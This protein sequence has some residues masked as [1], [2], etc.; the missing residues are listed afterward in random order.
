MVSRTGFEV[1]PHRDPSVPLNTESEYAHVTVT[2]VVGNMT[3]TYDIPK[4]NDLETGVVEY[5]PDRFRRRTDV[6]KKTGPHIKALTFSVHPFPTDDGG[7][8]MIVTMKQGTDYENQ[9]VDADDL[10]DRR[11]R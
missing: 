5:E 8:L 4:A 10:Q 1:P 9:K 2:V 6:L 11:D 7:D 3:T